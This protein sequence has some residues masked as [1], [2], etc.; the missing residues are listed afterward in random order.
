IESPSLTIPSCVCCVPLALAAASCWFLA[1]SAS[2]CL[3]NLL[4]APDS[5]LS[6]LTTTV[7]TLAIG[8][9]SGMGKPSA[10]RDEHHPRRVVHHADTDRERMELAARRPV[11]GQPS[12]GPGVVLGAADHDVFFCSASS[13]AL[14]PGASTDQAST[15]RKFC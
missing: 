3:F 5:S 7:L 6:S 2:I 1:I 4:I 14:K 11:G 10:F 12:I 8:C 15:S 9:S 13:S